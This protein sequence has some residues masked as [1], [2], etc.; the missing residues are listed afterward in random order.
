[1]L[2]VFQEFS[3]TGDKD[4]LTSFLAR[5]VKALPSNWKRNPKREKE[6]NRHPLAGNARQFAFSVDGERN[7]PPVDV[8]LLRRDPIVSVSNVV[9]RELGQ[10]T[11]QQYNHFVVQLSRTATPLAASLGLSATLTSDEQ[12]IQDILGPAAYKALKAFSGAANKTTGSS[13]PLDQRRWLKF[14]VLKHLNE[15]ELSPELLVRW[16][17]EEESWPETEAQDLGSE[18]DFADE[19]LSA[20]DAER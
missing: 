16:F 4:K 9:P 20:Y 6:V 11:R 18:L 7:Y 3:I 14:L 12:D 5:L 1:L 17:V 10:L 8:F 2:E 13:H 15:A 19:L